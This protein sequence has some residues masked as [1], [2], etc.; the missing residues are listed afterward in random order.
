VETGAKLLYDPRSVTNQQNRLVNMAQ[1]EDL[2]YT[3]SD[4]LQLAG[5]KYGWQHR[6]P[7]PSICLP[8]LTRNSAD[9]HDLAMYLSHEAPVKRRVLTLDYRGRGRSQYDRNWENYNI[10]VEADDVVQGVIAAGLSHGAFIGTSRGGLIIMVLA[11]MKPGLLSRIVF[12]DIGPEIDGPG[13]VRIKNMIETS[14]PVRT[15]QE[16]A[17]SLEQIGKRDFPKRTPAEW[18]EQARLIYRE[19]KGKLLRNH[20]PK[21][22]MVMKALNLDEPIPSLWPQFAGLAK[23]PL[24]LIRGGL[25]DLLTEQTVEKMQAK[26]GQMKLITVPDQGH[27]PDL[28]TPGLAKAIDDFISD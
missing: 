12:N 8:G 10:L 6:G 16:A 25:S 9:F 24:L 18:E 7:L 26:H 15:W 28:G 13:L 2:T 21:L 11:A 19:E 23:I 27:A 22:A 14:K 5:R 4:G 20:D 1:W 3:S 17:V